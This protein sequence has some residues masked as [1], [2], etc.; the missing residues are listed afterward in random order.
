MLCVSDSSDDSDSDPLPAADGSA[1]SRQLVELARPQMFWEVNGDVLIGSMSNRINDD[2]L[3]NMLRYQTQFTSDLSALS[4]KLE[5]LQVRYSTTSMTPLHVASADT[6]VKKTK[7]RMK[8]SRLALGVTV[9][10][11]GSLAITLNSDRYL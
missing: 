8:T 6:K 11:D 5:R 7:T 10:L 9:I 1:D 4:N 2:I 3:A